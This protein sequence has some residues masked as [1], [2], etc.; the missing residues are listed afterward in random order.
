MG[1]VERQLLDEERVAFGPSEDF[2][3][4]LVRNLL[5]HGQLAQQCRAVR[6][7]ERPQAYGRETLNPGS[8]SAAGFQQLGPGRAD[9]QVGAVAASGQPLDHL[10][11]LLAGPVQV[12]DDDQGGCAGRAGA[13]KPGPCPSEL[14][15]HQRR[16]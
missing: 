15:G 3:S 12:L 10:Q 16:L 4:D 13:K 2:A 7:A 5:S 8:E 1:Q 14:V 9:Q 6:V 11:H